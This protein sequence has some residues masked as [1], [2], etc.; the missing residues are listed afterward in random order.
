MNIPFYICSNNTTHLDSTYQAYQKQLF[1]NGINTEI[2]CIEQANA[3]FLRQNPTL[4][5]LLDSDGLS[6]CA[7]GMKMNPDWQAEIPRL[8]RATLK[9]EMIA[10]ACNLSEKPNLL[11]ATAGLGHDALLM[12]YL[13]ANVTLIERNPI[14]YLLL[15]NQLDLAKEHP[16]LKTVAERIHLIF[17]DA[18]QQLQL[19]CEN[20]QKFDVIYLDPMFPQRHQNNAKKAQV[21]KQMQILHLLL[22]DNI[23]QAQNPHNLDLGDYLLPLA[24]KISPRVIVK[25][26]RHAI[27]LNNQQPNHQ[28]QGD[29]CRFDAYFQQLDGF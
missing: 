6:L 11:D 16:F 25:R 3:K 15:K 12:A 10:R 9:S 1:D 18:K 26:P 8:K 2:H 19:L 5:L 28:W 27:F 21:K 22:E 17:N 4:S 20:N 29:A 23:E 13:G 24:Q 7:N 14:L